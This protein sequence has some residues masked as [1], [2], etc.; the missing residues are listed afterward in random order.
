[1]IEINKINL[2]QGHLISMMVLCQIGFGNAISYLLPGWEQWV[3][4]ISF[5][6]TE[7]TIEIQNQV[8]TV[9]SAQP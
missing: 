4:Y 1:M 3:Y 6:W 9:I 8:M 2:K 5:K 7:F